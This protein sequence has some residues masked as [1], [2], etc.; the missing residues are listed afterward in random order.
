M[1]LVDEHDGDFEG[2][3]AELGQGAKVDVVRVSSWLRLSVTRGCDRSCMVVRS[4]RSRLGDA[5]FPKVWLY[6]HAVVNARRVVHSRGHVIL[7]DHTH[8]LLPP[9]LSAGVRTGF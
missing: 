7:C 2:F 9:W 3:G 8:I 4:D 1:S 6:A 5:F